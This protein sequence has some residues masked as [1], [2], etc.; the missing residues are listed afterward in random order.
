MTDRSRDPVG[1]TSIRRATGT[2]RTYSTTPT[3]SPGATSPTAERL[4]IG[5][6]DEFVQHHA[7]RH[8]RPA[9]PGLP[10]WADAWLDFPSMTGSSGT[11]AIKVPAR[12]P[13]L[14]VDHDLPPGSASHLAK[15]YD[16]FYDGTS[17][18]SIPWAHYWGSTPTASQRPVGS[19]S[20]RPRTPRASGTRS[21]TSAHRASAPS[22]RPTCPRSSRSP[23]P[24]SSAPASGDSLRARPPACRAFLTGFVFPDQPAAATYRQMGNGVNV[25][26]VW[27]VFREHVRARPG[28][29]CSQR[30]RAVRSW[31]PS[32][33]HPSGRMRSLR[34]ISRRT[35]DSTATD[36]GL[37]V[38]CCR[39]AHI[40]L[41]AHSSFRPR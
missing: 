12:S 25:G 14:M 7:T 39:G 1:R 2:W 33:L 6:W 3:T 26:A 34:V 10:V 35:A 15:N 29:P 27:H 13:R 38:I 4:W 23:R 11:P 19:S 36:T 16:L 8:G 30:K 18:R 24:R 22:A 17:R 40:Q 9:L 5:A 32:L 37:K 31:T 21:C 20:G 41:T 28:S